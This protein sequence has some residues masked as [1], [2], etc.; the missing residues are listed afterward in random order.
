[1]CEKGGLKE[2]E[3]FKLGI[4]I[5]KESGK[6][7]EKDACWRTSGHAHLR[8]ISSLL[9]KWWENEARK[10]L[11]WVHGRY[12]NLKFIITLPV[13]EDIFWC[14]STITVTRGSQLANCA[15]LAVTDWP[16]CY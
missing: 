6:K 11:A 3:P 10:C 2:G 1:M 16:T 15:S 4:M 8:S 7:K 14:A 12:L 5:A 13:P 9:L